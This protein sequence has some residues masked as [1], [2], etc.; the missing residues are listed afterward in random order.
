MIGITAV[1]KVDDTY[2][3]LFDVNSYETF[4]QVQSEA[5]LRSLASQYSYD[6]CNEGDNELLTLRGGKDEPSKVLVKELQERLDRAGI[7]I[8]EARISHLSYAPEIAETMLKR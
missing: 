3:A 5:A 1:Y 6:I 4:V 7:K 8:L 2:K